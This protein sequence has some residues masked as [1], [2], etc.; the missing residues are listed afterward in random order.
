MVAHKNY[1]SENKRA[2]RGYGKGRNLGSSKNNA[3]WMCGLHSVV[4][5]LQNKKRRYSRLL[6]TKEAFDTLQTA[7]PKI[8]LTTSQRITIPS[9]L[10]LSENIPN[11]EIVKRAKI[12]ALF[13]QQSA[14]QSLAL[15]CQPL[16]SPSLTEILSR[17]NYLDGERSCIVVLDRAQDPRNIG[18]VLRSACFFGVKAV[19]LANGHTPKENAAMAK[20]A[21]GALEIVPILRLNLAQALIKLGG[22]ADKKNARGE[23]KQEYWDRQPWVRIALEDASHE[24]VAWGE[25][26]EELKE[27]TKIAL[28]FGAEDAGIRPL[29]RR[30]CDISLYLQNHTKSEH[31]SKLVNSSSD[32]AKI[33]KPHPISSSMPSPIGSLNLS[34]AVAATLALLAQQNSNDT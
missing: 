18:A 34:N 30:Q 2:Q 19:L 26:S 15:L 24:A 12:D 33:E 11:V 3:Y 29:V 10:S 28:V 25:H 21:S 22:K 5:A 7:L 9:A 1:D 31:N 23:E 17:K 27:A 8:A 32:K 4:A 20:A 6:A 13:P 14:H 16:E